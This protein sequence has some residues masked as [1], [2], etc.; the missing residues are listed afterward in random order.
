MRGQP[1]AT[2]GSNFW[3]T[4][5]ALSVVD[6]VTGA[7][8]P[9]GGTGVRSTWGMLNGRMCIDSQGEGVYDVTTYTAAPAK[10]AT[11]SIDYEMDVWIRERSDVAT[12]YGP[13]PGSSSQHPGDTHALFEVSYY[14]RF[15]PSE[16][17]S[18]IVVRS[19]RQDQG[20]VPMVKEPKIAAELRANGRFTEID[21]LRPNRTVATAAT[22]GQPEAP[23][24]ILFTRQAD[25]PSRVVAR[26]GVHAPNQA[27][28]CPGGCFST[29]MRAIRIAR[30]LPPAKNPFTSVA[31]PLADYSR[32]LWQNGAY[33][34]DGWASRS[35]GRD[36]AYPCDTTSDDKV[37]T[38]S[39]D[40]PTNVL[41]AQGHLVHHAGD[42]IYLRPYYHHPPKFTD[43]EQSRVSAFARTSMQDARR[44]ELGGWKPDNVGGGD[45]PDGPFSASFVLFNGWEGGRGP[46]DC[47]PL[48]VALAPGVESYGMVARYT[49]GGPF[50]LLGGQPTK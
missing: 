1:G 27:D 8:F 46:Q 6:P 2:V 32:P 36:K 3:N 33:G 43:A 42:P 44:W 19:F 20:G 13:L 30:N 14:Y 16:V 21:V 22:R 5:G 34:L 48:E 26:W 12:G 11:H 35:P 31:D 7:K 10:G 28:R 39:A 15:Y 41:D 23:K 47:E 49:L 29:S 37:T 38:C 9:L 17:G 24:A 50:A 45:D 18:L 25:D 4:K 40:Y